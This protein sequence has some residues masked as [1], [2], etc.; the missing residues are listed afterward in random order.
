MGFFFLI[1]LL[2]HRSS[3]AYECDFAKA[4]DCELNTQVCACSKDLTIDQE[5]TTRPYVCADLNYPRN[6]WIRDSL[7][8]RVV[9]A[10]PLKPVPHC[11]QFG[12]SES[13]T[14]EHGVSNKDDCE[15]QNGGAPRSGNYVSCTWCPGNTHFNKCRWKPWSCTCSKRDPLVD[16]PCNTNA[17]DRCDS[18]NMPA[19]MPL[20]CCS[21]QAQTK[22]ACFKT[23]SSG[24]VDCSTGRGGIAAISQ[25][26]H[27]AKVLKDLT[28]RW[29][30]ADTAP[31]TN[32]LYAKVPWKKIRAGISAG[33]ESDGHY[34]TIG[35]V[36]YSPSTKRKFIL[37]NAHNFLDYSEKVVKTS[38]NVIQPSS[39]GQD[40]QENPYT[41]FTRSGRSIG[42]FV[43][44]YG[45]TNSETTFDTAVVELEEN[46][47]T[48]CTMVTGIDEESK[49]LKELHVNG[50]GDAEVGDIV[51][52]HG[53]T[54]GLTKITVKKIT[55]KQVNGLDVKIYSLKND[56]GSCDWI[57]DDDV[58]NPS[59]SV[60]PGDSG[61]VAYKCDTSDTCRAICLYDGKAEAC[62]SVISILK[63][64]NTKFGTFIGIRTGLPN[65]IP[66]DVAVC[67]HPV[68]SGG[69][70]V[71]TSGLRA[72]VEQ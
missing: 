67:S 9:H 13:G 32:P 24:N 63:Q 34:W 11:A 66:A 29:S 53:R 60:N 50:A 16:L 62:I 59:G 69:N 33:Y 25:G 6:R 12:K 14:T 10:K 71:S 51:F 5:C 30:E 3:E 48:K 55:T 45:G 31:I 19:N 22:S 41:E 8:K 46:V 56:D 1:L 40:Q 27:N 68:V 43:W 57:D 17:N 49:R 21:N 39:H 58:N 23:V 28:F 38:V 64:L 44:H 4:V 20:M 15:G 2:L 7:D 54:D 36:L 65:E 18:T 35:A 26:I 47:E 52:I 61:S 70:G 37:T 72:Q 42:K